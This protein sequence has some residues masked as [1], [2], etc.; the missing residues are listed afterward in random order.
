MTA[1]PRERLVGLREAPTSSERSAFRAPLQAATW[2]SM[3]VRVCCRGHGN[4][5]DHT[6]DG[7][8][9]EARRRAGLLVTVWDGDTKNGHQKDDEYAAGG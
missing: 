1:P 4:Y 7:W 5:A 3:V 8:P 9:W 6:R 2:S